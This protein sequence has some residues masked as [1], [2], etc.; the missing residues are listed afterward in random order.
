LGGEALGR[1]ERGSSG[2]K[3]LREG[4]IMIPRFCLV[5]IFFASVANAQTKPP[6]FDVVSIKPERPGKFGHVGFDPTGYFATGVTLNLV[7]HQAYFAFN[8]CDKDSVVGAPDW[9]NKDTWDIETKVAPE[10]IAEYQRDHDNPDMPNPITRQMLQT[11]LA[12]RCKLVVHRVPA[13]MPAYAIQIAKNGPRLTQASPNE[14][15]PSGSIP[16]AEGG[17]LVP[18]QRG[19]T[20]HMNYYAV[21]MSTFAQSLRIRA[22]GPV[23][24]RTGLTGNYDFSLTWLS[25]GPDEREGYT[26]PGDPFPL[27][28]WNFGALGLRVERVQIPTEHIVIDHIEKPSEN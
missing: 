23:V 13:E 16:F 11:M 28:H 4:L 8:M 21:S 20:P 27:S 17:F 9:V 24:D 10:D 14:P 7:I 19:D 18:Y 22:H 15:Q 25:L 5:A 26:L 2:R 12:D 3:I 6:A 1:G